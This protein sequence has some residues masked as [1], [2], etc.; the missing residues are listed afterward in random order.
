MADQ[1]CGQWFSRVCGLPNVVD[2]PKKAISALHKIY[3][4]NVKR[5]SELSNKG[6]LNGAVNGMRPDGSSADESNLQSKEVWTGTTYGV[7]AAFL[8]EALALGDSPEFAE[9]RK[10]L[11]EAGFNTAQGIHDNGWKTL[12]Y[13]FATPEA[14]DLKGDFRSLGYMR[15]LSIW[16]MNWNDMLIKGKSDEE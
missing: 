6:K 5:W 8:S 12:G 15:P 7:A 11:W 10:F 16:S 3:D 1:L 4:L 9:E 2:E 13:S 14:W